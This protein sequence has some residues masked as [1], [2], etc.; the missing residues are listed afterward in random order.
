AARW[1]SARKER[2]ITA[3]VVT[4]GLLTASA[5]TARNVLRPWS[6]SVALWTRVVALNPR[7]DVGLYNL[8]AALAEAGR[9]DEAAARYR[10]VLALIPD[11][12]DAKANLNRL[13]A[14]RFEREG[15]G[16]A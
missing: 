16:L 9:D 6:D 14:A 1:A 13:D 7:H 3:A 2:V 15:N 10:E 8:G 12:A 4:I 11:H 5:L